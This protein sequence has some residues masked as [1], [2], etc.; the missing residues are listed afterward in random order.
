MRLVVTRR[1]LGS[2]IGSSQQ[3]AQFCIARAADGQL[4]LVVENGNAAVLFGQLY[5]CQPRH[6]QNKAAVD[7]QEPSSRKLLFEFAERLFLQVIAAG[8]A[9]RYVVV[10]RLNVVDLFHRNH[11]H[12]GAIPYEKEINCRALAMGL[13]KISSG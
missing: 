1:G 10:L 13:K 6:I 11:V 2:W 12:M 3:I 7:A 8:R 4:S 9:D 5:L